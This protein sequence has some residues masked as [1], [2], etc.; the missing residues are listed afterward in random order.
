M[1]TNTQLVIQILAILVAAIGLAAAII[2]L[3]TAYKKQKPTDSGGDSV[4]STQTTESSVGTGNITGD[5]NTQT[6]NVTIGN[7]RT[8]PEEDVYDDDVMLQS[9]Y[10]SLFAE[11][12]KVHHET[13]SIQNLGHGRIEGEV[14]LDSEYTYKLSGTFKNRILTGEY[15]SVGRFVD[16]RGT[17]NLKLIDQDILTGF[18]S[19]S[20]VSMNFD[21]QIRMSPYIWISGDNTDLIN[22][23]YQFCS[24]CHMTNKTCCCASDEIDMPVL[25]KND[26]QQIQALSPRSHRLKFFSSNIGQ[27]SVRQM[28]SK[29]FERNGKTHYACH[30]YDV[31]NNICTIYD[32]RP[33][34]CRLFPFDI[35]LDAITNEYW[36]GYYDDL[37][38]R[39]LP[40]ESIMKRY[41][42]ILRPFI[43]LMFPYANIVTLD[44]VCEKLKNAH[45]TRLYKLNDF[46]F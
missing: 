27:T 20:K 5:G 40:D 19:F 28:K 6:I 13:I 32:T 33:V 37:C 23:T 46:I 35:K 4:D 22:G 42:H 14:Y 44:S 43:F 21:D 7:Q 18:C 1:N 2:K 34:D 3:I 31:K 15:T 16:E 36:I 45:F 11:N 41:A 26:A 38:E 24:E 29:A 9:S 8:T 17:V 30:F 12:G 25:L 39:S 10:T